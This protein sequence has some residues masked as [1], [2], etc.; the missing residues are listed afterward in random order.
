MNRTILPMWNRLTGEIDFEVIVYNRHPTEL[1]S[2]PNSIIR[3]LSA[4]YPSHVSSPFALG[5]IR[6]IRG[7]AR[8]RVQPI[9]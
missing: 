8:G 4:R 6:D 2:V 7:M 5:H 3:A 9:R 1:Q